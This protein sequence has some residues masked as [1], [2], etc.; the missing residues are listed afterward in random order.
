[1][2]RKSKQQQGWVSSR[3]VPFRPEEWARLD[4]MAAQQGIT[5]TML[6]REWV[7]LRLDSMPLMP[8]NLTIEELREIKGAVSPVS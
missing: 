3:G 2:R 4:A 1:M 6:I 7:R 8:E 5:A